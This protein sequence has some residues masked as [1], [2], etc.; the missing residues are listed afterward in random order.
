MAGGAEG[1]CSCTAT[2]LPRGNVEVWTLWKMPSRTGHLI[3]DLSLVD[4]AFRRQG[5]PAGEVMCIMQLL[6]SQRIRRRPESQTAA[7]AL[8]D[9]AAVVL[10][11]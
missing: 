6:V 9:V 11:E 1:L 2:S 5:G 7:H 10:R 4:V 3:K 8:C